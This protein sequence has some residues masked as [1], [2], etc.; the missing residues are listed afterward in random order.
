VLSYAVEQR[1]REI[2]VR[3]ALGA[4]AGSITRLVRSQL[5]RPVGVGLGLGTALASA[6]AAL[7]LA[8][9]FASEVTDVVTVLDPLAYAGSLTCII[10]A[11]FLAAWI[12]ARRAARIDPIET[13]RRD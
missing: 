10:A 5:M 12:P 13:L 1:A 3:M 2:G 11:C 8:T 9:R 4:P 6:L 7:L